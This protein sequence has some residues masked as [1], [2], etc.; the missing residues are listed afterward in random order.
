MTMVTVVVNPVVVRLSH[1][2]MCGLYVVVYKESG[3]VR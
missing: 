3:C 2:N 1:V